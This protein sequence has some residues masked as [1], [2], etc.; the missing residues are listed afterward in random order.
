MKPKVRFQ[1]STC[2]FSYLKT[3]K[4]N[5]L[6]HFCMVFVWFDSYFDFNHLE[7]FFCWRFFSSGVVLI[8][9]GRWADEG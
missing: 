2:L 9:S 7:H 8:S 1:V 3:V 4:P 5:I 6:I